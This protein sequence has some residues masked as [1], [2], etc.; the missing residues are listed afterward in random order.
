MRIWGKLVAA[1]ALPLML[2]GCLWGPGKFTSDL[3]L[4]KN[5]T[6]VLDYRGEIMLQM[7]DDRGSQPSPWS[8]DMAK[9]FADGSSKVE[10]GI[11]QVALEPPADSD[12]NPEEER[13]CTAAEIA[14]L[15][16]EY[17]KKVAE[18]AEAKRKENEEMAKLFGLP[19]S[20]DESNRRFAAN[21]MKHK[22]WRSV[23]YKGKGLFEVDYHFEGR[24]D[25]DFAF[26]LMPD[27]DLMIPFITIRPRIDGSV[28]VNAPAFTG[29]SGPFGARAKAM[30]LPDKGSEGPVSRA[31]GRFTITTDGEILTN[32]SEDGPS[33]APGGRKVQWDVDSGSTR[34]PEM[35]VRL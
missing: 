35:M 12:A 30:G 9:C 13:P 23:T 32:N 16:S 6:F 1:A 11:V 3:S 26:P 31:Q 22:G 14:K 19:G 8:D 15:K 2:A 29:A 25:Q 5:G 20:D 21:L 34:I 7:P 27:S 28:K 33:A 10:E 4:R 18:R 17:A 24:L